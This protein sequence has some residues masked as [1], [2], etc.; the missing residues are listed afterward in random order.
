VQ[1]SQDDARTAAPIPGGQGV[2]APRKRQMDRD[3]DDVR[4]GLARRRPL[5]EVLVPVLHGPIGR[6]CAGDAGQREGGGQDVLAEARMRILRVEGVDEQRQPPL[7][8]SRQE[9][10]I[11]RGRCAHLFG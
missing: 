2:G 3:S 7:D 6:G 4:R 9:T 1:S 10:R 5:E 8:R 11:Q